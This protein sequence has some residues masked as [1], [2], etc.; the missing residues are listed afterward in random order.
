M[1]VPRLG[2]LEKEVMDILWDCPAEL[3]TR[4]VLEQTSHTL[5]YTTIAT[6]LNNLVKKG[7]VERVHA[8]RTWAFRP[9]RSRGEYVAGLMAE[10]LTASPDRR[11]SL[12]R[13]VEVMSDD[14]VTMLRG[15]LSTND[16]T[17]RAEHGSTP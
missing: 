2:T 8:G 7:L 3:C 14:D 15:L 13:F 11:S 10:A 6:V 1:R 5:A 4:D 9:L 16:P 17:D 12:V